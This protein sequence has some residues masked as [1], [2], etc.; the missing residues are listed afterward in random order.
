MAVFFL[1]IYRAFSLEY[2]VSSKIFIVTAEIRSANHGICPIDAL[3][4]NN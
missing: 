1:Q 4:I 2:E 3:Y